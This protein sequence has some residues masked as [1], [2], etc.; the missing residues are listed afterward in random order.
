MFVLKFMVKMWFGVIINWLIVLCR[1]FIFNC[2]VMEI[3]IKV[4]GVKIWV[5]CLF[6]RMC[7]VLGNR[8]LF[9]KFFLVRFNMWVVV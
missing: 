7:C 3:L 1:W 2:V 5:R 4:F 6:C 9:W 8:V